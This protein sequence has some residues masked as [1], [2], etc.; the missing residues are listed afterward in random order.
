MPPITVQSIKCIDEQ[1]IVLFNQSW[2]QED[3]EILH[4]FLLSKIPN[5]Q[6]KEITLGADREDV[7][8]QWSN[9]EFILSFDY[10][11]QSCWFHAQD[12]MSMKKIQS[13]FH[14]LIKS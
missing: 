1:I 3:I 7:R 11:S 6:Q 10:Y 4:Q 8:F 2:F 14:L 13:L 5:H 12:E 9:A